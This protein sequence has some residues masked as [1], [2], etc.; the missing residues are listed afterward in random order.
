MKYS[1]IIPCYNEEMNIHGLVET[2]DFVRGD[3]NIE[4]IL[5]ENGSKDRTGECLKRECDGRRQFQI[6]FV[7]K[8]IGYGYGVVQ[9]IKVA[10]GDYIGWL[11]A[12][13]QVNPA[14]MIQFTDFIE[15]S[16][17]KTDYF[18]K[19]IRQNRRLFDRFFTAGMT[20]Y[21]SIMLGT[22]VYDIGAIPVL[23]H[24]SLLERLDG[25][26][27]YDFSIETYVYY[28]AKKSNLCIKRFP[29]ALE[30]RKK[31]QSSW[32]KGLSSKICQ[33][34]IIMNDIRKIKKGELVR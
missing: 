5:V 3:R 29:V 28:K 32:D 4:Y 22:Y 11:H 18:L 26:I 7:E 25:K 9:G 33:S 10:Q 6:V 14:E 27:P 21:A 20:V 23:F 15:E 16:G 19:G 24:R 34:K 12:D 17:D 2:L 1:I 31:G 30:R 13:L 8:N